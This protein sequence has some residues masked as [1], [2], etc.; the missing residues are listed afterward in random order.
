VALQL[1]ANNFERDFMS[2]LDT[3]V[4][5]ALVCAQRVRDTHTPRARVP[6]RGRGH[7][8]SATF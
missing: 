5:S 2:T 7:R 1:R 6:Q 8:C 3:A 4:E